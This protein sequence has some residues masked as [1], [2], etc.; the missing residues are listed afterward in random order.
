MSNKILVAMSGGV[1]SSAAALL[2]K[3]KGYECEGGTMRLFVPEGVDATEGER[4]AQRVSDALGI[5]FHLFDM[6]KE[7]TDTVMEN[8][9]KCYLEGETPNPC[10]VCNREIKFGLLLK[11]AIELGFDKIA[12]GHYARVEY[13]NGRYAVKKGMSS[14]KDQ[15]YVL[16]CLTQEQLSHVILPLGGLSKPEV[17]EIAEKS[18]LPVAHKSESQDICFVP[19]GDY[20]AFIERHTGKSFPAG[21]FTDTEGKVLGRHKGIINY[22]VGQRRGLG[23]SLKAPLYV[24]SKDAAQNKVVLCPNEQLFEK[25]LDCREANWVGVEMP[26]SPLRVEAKIRYRHAA[27]P[28]TVWATGENSFHLEFDEPQRAISPGQSCV[29]YIGDILAGGGIIE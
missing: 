2:L 27:A 12:T 28:A 11:K 29:L 7:F 18:G 25:K 16:W 26:A 8:F 1:D 3:E 13:E 4:D 9:S 22:T 17:R 10:V 21:D 19:D 14:E 24:K 23:L 15:S 20:A 5:P 6:Q